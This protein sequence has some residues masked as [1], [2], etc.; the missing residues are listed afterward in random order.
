MYLAGQSLL[1][2]DTKERMC[3][4]SVLHLSKN[5][6]MPNV[7]FVPAPSQ[8]IPPSSPICLHVHA[9]SA[10]SRVYKAILMIV[11]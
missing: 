3:S 8:L 10:S 6:S 11:T 5:Y 2:V 4:D 1:S 9:Q 7:A